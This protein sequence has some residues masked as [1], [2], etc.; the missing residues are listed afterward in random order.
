[1]TRPAP[2]L[3]ASERRTQLLHATRC[4]VDRGGYSTLT[5][6]AVAREANVTKPV[7]YSAFANRDD[8]MTRL[9]EVE[10]ARVVAEISA[11]IEF[12]AHGRSPQNLGEMVVLGLDRVL[13]IVCQQPQ[14][15]RLILIGVHG[16]PREV[17]EAIDE[18]RR[19]LTA[20]V[21][22]VIG[23]APALARTDV[24]LLATML[25]ALGEHAATL[26]LTEPEHFGPARFKDA[27]QALL[28]AAC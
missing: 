13:D 27:L 25:V 2:R 5:M 21:A 1:M 24:E 7:V 19:I 23:R 4:V 26:V 20:Q 16:S 10:G 14:R 17:R 11:A 8:A 12:A 22:A 6:E 28:S 9:L 3:P 15:Y 18:G